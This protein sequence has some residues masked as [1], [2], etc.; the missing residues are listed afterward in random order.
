MTVAAAAP[1]VHIAA[2]EANAREMPA[3]AVENAD[4]SVILFPEL[5]ITGYTGAAAAPGHMV[6]LDTPDA[7]RC[8]CGRWG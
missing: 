7:A 6:I 1:R 5:A 4:A 2:T 3:L 8:T